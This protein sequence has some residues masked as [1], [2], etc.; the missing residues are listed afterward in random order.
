MKA[1]IVDDE[2]HVREAIKLLVPWAAHGIDEVLEAQDGLE[3]IRQIEANRPELIFTDMMMPLKDGRALLVWLQE[4]YPTGKTIV[5]SG[6]DDFEL[7]RHTMRYGGLDYI[8]K[9]IDGEQLESAVAE[10]VGCWRREESERQKQQER[11]MERNQYKPVYWE[12]I[13]SDLL[14]GQAGFESYAAALRSE[15]QLPD[16]MPRARVAVLSLDSLPAALR[17]KFATHPD[18]L[19]FSLTNIANEIL[20]RGGRRTGV[21]FRHWNSDNEIALLLY[22][23]TGEPPPE[24]T[25]LEEGIRAVF[26]TQLSIGVSRSHAI[27]EELHAAYL[28]ARGALRRRNALNACK[29]VFIYAAEPDPGPHLSFGDVAEAVRLAVRSGSAEQIGKALDAWF[30]AIRRRGRLSLEEYERWTHEFNAFRRRWL[31]E[32]LGEQAVAPAAGE[33]VAPTDAE[34]DFSLARWREQ[35]LEALV[36]LSRLA[37]GQ[38]AQENNV[39]YDIA[40]YV[41]ANYQEEITLQEIASHFYLSREYISRKFKQEFGINLSDYLTDIRMDKARLLLLNPHLRIAQVAQMVG[42]EDEKYFSKV[43]KKMVGQSPNEYRK[44]NQP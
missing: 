7:V 15:F 4:H 41:Q 25:A 13:W 14:A 38:Q 29:G 3:A 10:A 8:L 37:L 24:L 28:E 42:Y 2:K 35:W 33:T 1:I 43:F 23:P 12:K 16:A 44:E 30:D 39:I 40:K 32:W 19:Y 21:A 6:H 9:P 34:G 5:I 11:N 27:P 17:T 18:L 22:A 20:Q 31:A 36:A 26:R